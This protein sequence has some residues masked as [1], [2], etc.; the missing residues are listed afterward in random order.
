MKENY[1]QPSLV[2]GMSV[3]DILNMDNRT[4]NKLTK[5][6]LRLVTGRLVSAANKRLRTFERSDKTSPA[7]YQ[8]RASGGAFSTKG[9]DL[10]AHRAEYARAKGFM[11]SKT[12]TV[13][14]YKKVMKQTVETL[15]EKGIYTTQERAG[16]IFGLYDR[17]KEMD[18][19]IEERGLKYKI[20]ADIEKRM[21]GTTDEDL[22]NALESM[23]DRITEISVSFI[24]IIAPLKT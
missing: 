13:G 6:E 15:A 1:K 12:G 18:P 11:T 20:V 3:R 2:S 19:S 24:C 10:N 14:Q 21:S 23:R 16:H 22:D 4:F 17:L 9:K 7:T 8:V 5:S